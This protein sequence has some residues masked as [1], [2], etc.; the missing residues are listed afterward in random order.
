[1]DLEEFTRTAQLKEELLVAIEKE[2][3]SKNI[4]QG[5]VAR[6]I[7]AL[8]RNINQIMGRKKN[9]TLDFLVKMAESI[10][11]DVQMKIK[12]SRD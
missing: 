6:R 3:A 10:D 4:S 1:M 9:V 7:G 8:R 12:R 2:M 11:L 5:E